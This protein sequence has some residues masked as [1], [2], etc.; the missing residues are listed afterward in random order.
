MNDAR[1]VKTE[2]TTCSPKLT[3]E[4]REAVR[5]YIT[6]IQSNPVTDK[7]GYGLRWHFTTRHI[8]TLLS[9]GLPHL[10][11]GNRRVRIVVEEADRW[12]HERFGVQRRNSRKAKQPPAQ[13]G[14][15]EVGGAS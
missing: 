10:K 9:Q 11:I 3:S 6:E 4:L 13:L 15:S 1:L 12:M 2:T 7:T 8:D 5:A 14:S